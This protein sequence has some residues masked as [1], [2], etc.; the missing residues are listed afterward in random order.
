MLKA[1]E[2][3]LV[4]R[5]WN[6][7]RLIKEEA[8]VREMPLLREMPQEAENEGEKYP[9]FFLLPAFRLP[10]VPPLSW[11]NTDRSRLRRA[12]SRSQPHLAAMV[13]NRAENRE[14]L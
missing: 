4:G 2:P 14:W 7:N 1:G 9:G 12:A 10:L 6:Q 13:Q 5:R 3:R 8:P 11:P